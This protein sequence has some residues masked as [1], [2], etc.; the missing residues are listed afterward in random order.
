MVGRMSAIFRRSPCSNIGLAF[1]YQRFSIRGVNLEGYVS[2]RNACRPR[3]AFHKVVAAGKIRTVLED[4][5]R[6]LGRARHG[7]LQHGW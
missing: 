1:S 5:G 7:G 4:G 3:V 6:W 2:R